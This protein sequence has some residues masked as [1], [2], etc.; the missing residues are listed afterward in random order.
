MISFGV[1]MTIQITRPEVEDLIDQRLKTDA[2][3]DAEDVG[4]FRRFAAI[5]T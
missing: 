1:R 2:F 5:T 3:K 4:L